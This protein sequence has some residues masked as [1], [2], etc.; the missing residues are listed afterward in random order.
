MPIAIS[1]APPPKAG[2]RRFLPRTSTALPEAGRGERGAKLP[3]RCGARRRPALAARGHAGGADGGDRAADQAA[4]CTSMPPSRPRRSKPVW[5]GAVPGPWRWLLDNLDIDRRWSADPRH[6]PDRRRDR[7]HWQPRGAVAGLCPVTE[8]NLGDGIFLARAPILG[9]RAD[10]DRNRSEH[11]DRCAPASSV[12]S[13]IRSAS[14]SVA[15]RSFRLREPSVGE[16]LFQAALAGA[17]GARRRN[18]DCARRPGRYR[19]PEHGPS[20]L[21][22]RLCRHHSRSLDLRRRTGAIDC[23]WRAGTLQVAE[24]QACRGRGYC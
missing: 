23:V 12:R 11:P 9:R 20:R 5:P 8:A 18:R 2:Q 10:R 22:R 19:E 14:R 21:R 15:A 1:A 13:N 16:T 6:P 4:R 17:G 3:R 7:P 24:R